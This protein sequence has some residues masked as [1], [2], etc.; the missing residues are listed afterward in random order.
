M[1]NLDGLEL[2][3]SQHA[4]SIR[5][6][7]YAMQT[8]AVD[9]VRAAK[10]ELTYWAADVV[11]KAISAAL[12]AATTATSSA[13]GAQEI[14]GGDA[15]S[16]A[17]L[18]SGDILTT[19]LVANAKTRLMSTTVKYWSGSTEG[20]SSDYKN[21]WLNTPEEPFVLFIA[22]ENENAFLKDSQF[23]NASE[24]GNNDIVLNGEIG[25]YLGT[26]IVVTSNT[27]RFTDGGGA[28]VIGHTCLLLKAKKAS[29]LAWGLPPTL[30]I[31]DYPSNLQTRIILAMNYATSVFYTDAIVKIWVTDA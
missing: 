9:L 17:T 23:V 18:A 10:E 14:F 11:D 1:D 16:K 28:S 15:Y 30:K 6:S 4:Y 2:S 13:R 19:D 24:Y 22:P 3:P 29:A 26:K 7:D 20:D 25:R 21:P 12:A 8:N 27:P 5:L 31:F